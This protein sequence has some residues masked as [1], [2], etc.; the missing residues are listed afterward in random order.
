MA[1]KGRLVRRPTENQALA[2]IRR[3]AKKLKLSE[4]GYIRYC[5]RFGEIIVRGVP[6][7]A[8]LEHARQLDLAGL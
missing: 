4:Q 6:D 5:V 1:K 8:K 7:Q 3:Q 2:R